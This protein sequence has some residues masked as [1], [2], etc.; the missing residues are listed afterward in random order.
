MK[1]SKRTEYGLKA[2]IRL[3]MHHG[4]GYLQSREIAFQERLPAKFL[5]S[6]LLALRSE[7]LLESKVGAGGGYRLLRA[8]EQIGVS[9]IIEAL[10][11][12]EADDD[13]ALRPDD[14]VAA[15]TVGGQ[16]LGIV[17]TRLQ[18]AYVKALSDL[19]LAELTSEATQRAESGQPLMYH[20]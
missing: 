10:E 12:R 8:P 14:E 16:A 11:P 15:P 7:R 17:T 1:L 3:A 2:A 6:I 18:E 4:A 19:T 13:A 20:I 9:E 5:E